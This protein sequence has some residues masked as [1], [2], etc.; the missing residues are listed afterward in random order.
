MANRGFWP[1]SLFGIAAKAAV[2]MGQSTKEP[3]IH[4]VT[5]ARG[6]YRPR[7]ID[8]KAFP[9]IAR[10]C[11]GCGAMFKSDVPV[12]I[13]RICPKCE[14]SEHRDNGLFGPGACV[15]NDGGWSSNDVED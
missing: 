8:R 12:N 3:S 4:Q 6:H 15:I 2:V 7:N 11:L 10:R 9:L 1:L 5:R 13:N 14:S